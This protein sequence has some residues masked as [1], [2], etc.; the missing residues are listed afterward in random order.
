MFSDLDH[1]ASREGE[2][3][4]RLD[5]LDPERR[6]QDATSPA[7]PGR[8]AS[9]ASTPRPR[10]LPDLQQQQQRQ[11]AATARRT[12]DRARDAARPHRQDGDAR[13]GPTRPSPAPDRHVMGD[14]QRLPNGNTIIAYRRKGMHRTRSTRRSDR[15]AD[16]TCG[17]S[18]LRL[19]REARDAVRPAAA[20]NAR[21]QIRQI[22]DP[23]MR[24]PDHCLL[25]AACRFRRSC[26]PAAAAI[27]HPAATAGCTS[28]P[29]RSPSSRSPA[30]GPTIVASEANDYAF[31]STIT[32]PPV[33]VKS[34]SNLTFDWSGVTHD[35]L[36]HTLQPARISTP[37]G[38]ALEPQAGAIS[39]RS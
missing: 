27:R 7:T 13:S 33:T 1:S 21:R 38:H 22:E 19:H 39:R 25:L 20:S 31:S 28:R 2:A 16:R 3:V 9:T 34:M 8:A 17:H 12:I 4:R 26:R 36:G 15:A 23:P 10:R 29:S 14:V 11:R 5:G 35:F 37:P 18:E 32:L 30:T 6:D 24:T